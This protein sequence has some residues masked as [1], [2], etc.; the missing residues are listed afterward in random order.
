MDMKNILIRNLCL[1]ILS[2]LLM[3]CNSYSSL[4]INMLQCEELDNPLG[5]DN[6]SP[7]FS[8]LLQSEEQECKQTAYQILV[9]SS[10]KF[11]SE[12][13]AD[14]WDSGKTESDESVWVLYQGTPLVSKSLAYWK[15]RVWDEKGNVS[16]WSE[17]AFFAVGLLHTDDW[18]AKYIGMNYGQ[19]PPHSP[20]FHKTFLWDNKGQKAFL[21]INSLGYHEVYINGQ[22]VSDVVL[23]PAVSQFDKRSLVVTYDV[24]EF[25]QKGENDLV[26]WLGQGWYHDG[27]P[28]VIEG[29]PFVRAQLEELKDGLWGTSLITNASWEARESGYESTWRK[30]RLGGEIVDASRLLP[31]L[32]TASLSKVEWDTVKEVT[33]PSHQTTP[34]MVEANLIQKEFHPKSFQSVGDTAWI[35]DLGTNFTGW[36]KIKFPELEKQQRIQINYCDFLDEKGE[37]INNSNYDVYIASG[38]RNESFVNKF[39]YHAYRYLKLSNL[40]KAPALSDI[41]ACLI[42]TDYGGTSS[43]S[44][45]DDDLNAIHQMIQYTLNCLTLGGDLVDCPH[46][47]R[48]GYGGDGNAST[49]TMQTMYNMAPLYM[50]WMQAWRDCIREDGSM[51]HTAPNPFSAGGGPYWCGF[52]ITASWQT[53]VNYGDRRLLERYYPYM[54]QWLGYAQKY[55]KDGL[56]R[57]WPSTEYRN[58]YLGDWATPVGIDQTNPASIDVVNNSFMVTCYQTMAKI[59]K[60]LGKDQDVQPFV[61]K[62]EEL[63]QLIHKTFYDPKQKSYST[64]TQIDLIY[65]MLVGATPKE[66]LPD[67]QNTLFAVTADRFKGHLSA[68]LVG[69]P[70]ITEW[71]VRNRQADFMYSMLKKR[72]YP[73]YLY[74]LDNGATTTWEHWNGERSHIHNCYNGIGSWFYQALGGILPDENEPGYKH[75]FIQP[76]LV[77]SLTWVEVSK[78][79]PYGLLNVKWEKTNATFAMTIH[80]PIGCE[81]TLTIPV[82]AK[83]VFINDLKSDK[84]NDFKIR[85]GNYRIM[86][87]L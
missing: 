64:G 32:T 17:P 1:G 34:Q 68:G 21:H 51:P 14:L 26:I 81:A 63:E 70:V 41:T 54:Q 13:K 8:W 82:D 42:H 72:E 37:F 69:V 18:K 83:S 12:G 28:G 56:L 78:D 45:S 59:A 43:F 75:V 3:S 19:E 16:Q 79:T 86:C 52:I 84:L 6:T 60:V 33:I 20:Q 80:V 38:Q 40:K 67:V 77:E 36:T 73:G 10:E 58:W 48:L 35:F 61:E 44:C 66:E 85:S 50:N 24:T 74:M 27:L 62:A 57:Q 4:K 29:G 30:Y 47:E 65:P 87:N 9:A 71:A 49:L 39:N 76:Q 2:F 23:T 25:L 22:P 55:S 46:V 7:H 11:L 5:I 31:N 53:Y 15:V